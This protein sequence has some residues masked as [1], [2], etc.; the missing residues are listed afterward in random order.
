MAK[1][2][3]QTLH[4]VVRKIAEPVIEQ[5]QEDVG[6]GDVIHG[7]THRI[8]AKHCAKCQKKKQA[9]NRRLVFG[10]PK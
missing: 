1:F 5:E 4:R 8:G 10:R 2:V 9:A 6:L 3:N 7:V